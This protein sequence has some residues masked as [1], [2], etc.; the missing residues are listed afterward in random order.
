MKA[1][2]AITA[3]GLVLV[4]MLRPRPQIIDFSQDMEH[5]TFVLGAR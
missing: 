1:L 4:F 5:A 3:V 2:L